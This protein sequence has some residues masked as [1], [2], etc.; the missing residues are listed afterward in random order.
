MKLKHRIAAGGAV[1]AT[2]AGVLLI[3]AGAAHAAAPPWEASDPAAVGTLSF[4][5][6]SGN[7]ITSGSSGPDAPFAAY[8]VGSA[9]VRAGDKSAGL[10][11]ANPDPNS[12]PALW[13][14]EQVG[15]FTAYPLSSGPASIQ[16]M[17]QSQPVNKGGNSD[18]T[19]DGFRSDLSNP[20]TASGYDHVVQVRM[21]TADSNGQQTS[22]YDTADLLINDA[23]HTWTQIYPS[24][25]TTTSTTL[26]SNPNPSSQNQSVTLTATESANGGGHPAGSVQFKDGSSNIGSA[27]AV[28]GSGVASTSTTTLSVGSHNLSAVFTPTD[29]STYSGSTGTAT[30]VVNP[31]ATPTSTTL[32]VTQDGVA[33]DPATLTANVT[34]PGSTPNNAGTVSFYDN[35]SSTALN[36]S[37]VNGSS[38]VYTLNLPSGF[39]AGGHSVVAKFTPTDVTTFEASQS[40][41]QSFLT[42]PPTTGACAQSD[43]ACTDTQNIQATIPVGTLVIHTPYTADNPLDLGTLALNAGATEFTGHADFNNIVV[44]D[45]RS[46]GLGYTVSALASALSDGKSNPGST[47]NA[48]NVGLTTLQ[49]T[50]GNAFVGTVTPTDNPAAD[51]AVAPNDPGHKGLG[52]ATPHTVFTVDKGLGTVTVKGDLTLNAPTS[53]ES[54]LFQGTITFTVG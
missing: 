9:A 16:T 49:A 24:V 30:Q 28:N 35:N 43:S 48:Q 21:R 14:K 19:L 17:S 53:T 10:Y 4:Y 20:S 25:L 41:P 42:Q 54:G 29:T 47:I 1:V 22:S 46:G 33:G 45:T 15:L 31:P 8:A 37:P 12:Q 27:V 5:D 34:G 32:A 52:G 6:S 38:G 2:T 26:T 18:Q 13:Y 39:T 23:A 11:F 50:P 44:T 40:A 3:G 51:P 36:S 7:Q